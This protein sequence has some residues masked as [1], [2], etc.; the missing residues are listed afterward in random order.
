ML[1]LAEEKALRSKGFLYVAGID[2]VG[3]GPLA[4]PVV[5]AA[6]IIPFKIKRSPWLNNV[7]DSKLLSASQRELLYV[8]IREMA[9]TFGI[10]MV[11]SQTIDIRG[12]AAATHLA[13]KQA[14]DQLCPE[15]DYLLVDYV[16]LPELSLPQKGIVHGD[17]LC[18]SIACASILAKVTRDRLMVELD[19]VYPG[20][21]LA[22]HKG[23]GTRAHRTALAELGPCLQHRLSYEPVKASKSVQPKSKS[24]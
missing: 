9:V 20:Y 4:G 7:R 2:E 21:G 16:K 22:R 12:I 6:V 23:Y 19:S 13:M 5:A 8:H 3:R 1:S 18:F 24:I 15:P 14:V 11:S 10:G 17:R